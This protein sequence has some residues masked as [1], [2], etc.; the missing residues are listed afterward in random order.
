MCAMARLIDLRS[1]TVTQPTPAMR[2]AMA[3][4][5]VGDDVLDHD[6]TMATLEQRI[7]DLTGKAAA[8]W[9]PSGSMGN[10]IALMGHVGRGDLVL[11]TR[12]AHILGHELGTAAWLAGAMTYEL[13]WSL[14]PGVPDPAAV[15][16]EAQGGGAYYEL[17]PRLLE[18]ENTHNHAGGAIIPPDVYAALVDTAH[19][20]GLA[21]HLDGAR[22]WHAAAALGL[23]V[24]QVV[25]EADTVNVCLS[26][27]LAAPMGSVL[28]GP[29]GFIERA[30]RTRKM[31][32]GGVR[33]GGVV[34]A[35]GLVAL[36]Q[37]LPRIDDDRLTAQRLARGLA[38]LGFTVA[39]PQTNMVFVDSD[40]APRLAETWCAAGVLCLAMGPAVRLVTHREIDEA[41]V[42]AALDAIKATR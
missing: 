20:Y 25:G 15:A 37:E 30:R 34:A 6:P 22:V 17:T 18:L 35:A 32:G 11:A 41:A 13:E 27:G 5:E 33:Q 42:D 31:L 16:A 3:A 4:A 1:D 12:H 38:D 14:G 36:D 7:A 39:P 29:A 21:V 40:A 19:S 9:V 26:K 23:P 2:A 8:L 10:L 28:A 24:A